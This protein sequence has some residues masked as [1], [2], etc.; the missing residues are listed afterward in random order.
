[1]FKLI[2]NYTKTVVS[3]SWKLM[4]TNVLVVSTILNK[5]FL[6]ILHLNLNIK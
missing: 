2:K 6:R 1:M 3:E 4:N 5:L